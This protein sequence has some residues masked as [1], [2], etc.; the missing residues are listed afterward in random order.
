[1][2]A[3]GSEAQGSSMHAFPSRQGSTSGR[4]LE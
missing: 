4:E 3:G 2:D 1:M